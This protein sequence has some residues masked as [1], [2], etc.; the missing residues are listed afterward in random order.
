MTDT[1]SIEYEPNEAVVWRRCMAS[2][3]AVPVVERETPIDE[4][5]CPASIAAITHLLNN[6]KAEWAKGVCIDVAGQTQYWLTYD[7]RQDYSDGEFS[8]HHNA[9]YEVDSAAV[10]PKK[11]ETMIH[12]RIDRQ[13]RSG[14]ADAR[15][16][17][18]TLENERIMD[19]YK[20][21]KDA[22]DV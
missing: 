18:S 4:V 13:V 21:M 1:D 9:I 5:L 15:V 22:Y 20:A 12:G 10:Q 16:D 11:G 3:V 17:R 6:E 19:A 2:G 8:F 7:Q 14:T